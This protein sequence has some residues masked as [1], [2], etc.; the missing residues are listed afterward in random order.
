MILPHLR[1]TQISLIYLVVL[2]EAASVIL[3][4]TIGANGNANLFFI[5]PAGIVFG[6]NAKIDVG[7]SFLATTAQTIK[8]PDTEFSAVNDDDVILS[9]DFPVGLG[10]WE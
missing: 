7:G 9:I 1:T 5:N 6:E 10:F 4:E 8:F 3:M 2:R